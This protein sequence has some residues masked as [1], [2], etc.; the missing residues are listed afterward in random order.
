V[1]SAA[2]MR[3]VTVTSRVFVC[4]CVRGRQ[5]HISGEKESRKACLL[6]IVD[7]LLVASRQ[8]AITVYGIHVSSLLVLMFLRKFYAINS[9]LLHG[10]PKNQCAFLKK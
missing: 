8:T 7:L 9:D 3:R 6:V 10:A 2:L 5:T 4:P 1:R